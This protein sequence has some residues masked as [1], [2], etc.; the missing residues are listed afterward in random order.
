MVSGEGIAGLTTFL[1]RKESGEYG[2]G[3][4]VH[5]TDCPHLEWVFLPQFTQARNS[6]L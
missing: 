4:M 6:F 3:T 5:R 1:V 2:S